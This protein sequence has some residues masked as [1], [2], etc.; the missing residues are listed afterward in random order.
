MRTLC[1]AVFAC[2]AFACCAIACAQAETLDRIAV[3]VGKHVITRN[4]V[5]LYLR[6]AAFVDGKA[7]D[8]SGPSAR[9]AAQRMVDLYLVLQDAAATRAPEPPAS[10]VAALITPLRARYPGDEEYK[11]AL[12]HA[13]ITEHDLEQHLR[14][15]LWMMR[16]TDLRFRPEVQI[17]DQDLR[18]A[19]NALVAK[20]PAGSPPPAFEASRA[21]LEELVMNQHMLDALDR[22]LVMARTE[23]PILYRD[24]AF[25]S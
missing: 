11:A 7:P 20:L 9:Q 18:T 16:Y 24:A 12:A 5:L 17:S 23:T 6:V 3:T 8:I 4:D 2:G 15:G 21:K 25:R 14:D 19:F 10:D 22:W 1:A 13:G